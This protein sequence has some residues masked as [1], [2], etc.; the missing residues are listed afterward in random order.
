MHTSKRT[1]T[2]LLLLATLIPGL[3]SAE[4]R[5]R[6]IGKIVDA[7]GTPLEGV[8][9]AVSAPAIPGFRE[10]RVTDKKGVFTVDFRQI[11]VTYHYRF[12]KVGFMSMEAQQDWGKE[13]SQ[14]YQW[15]MHPSTAPVVE[16]A[17]PASASAPAVDAYNAG[18]VAFKAR[19]FAT[20]ETRLKEAIAHDPE[21]HQGWALLASVH[22]ELGHYQEAADT[23]EKAIALGSTQES[24]LV[25]RWQA[26][27]NLKDDVKAA[28]ALKDLEAIGRRTEEAKRLHNEAIALV[29][30]GDSAGA[31]TK[32]Q[33]ALAL[34]PNLQESQLGLATAGLKIGR[35]A[36]AASAAEAILKTEP[37]NEKALR[38]RFNACLALG[39][40]PRLIEALVG[41]AA[42]EPTIARDGLLKLAFDAYDANDNAA[43]KD[44]FGNVLKVDPK[45]PQA[46][47]YLGVIA[48][49]EG[50]T[51]EARS[52][53]ERFL[54]IAPGDPEANAAR[55]MLK[56]LGKS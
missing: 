52:Y 28:A 46:H 19:D 51:A 17:P 9:V 21:L 56:Y 49:G 3:A 47:Y 12:E 38:L 37:A 1:L 50:A 43:A 48:A 54:A 26:Y 35:N 4:R 53:L 29:K 30:A 25:A 32:F 10:T 11:D 6:L 41:L 22:L 36:E 34:D 31:F 13:G 2:G 27:Q 24:V 18:L 14:R 33:E 5:G 15:T 7:E 55:E 42:V 23:A 20:A 40:T 44:R 16:G 39:D 45:Q 8:S